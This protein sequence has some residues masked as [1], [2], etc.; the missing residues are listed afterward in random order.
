M[1]SVKPKLIIGMPIYNGEKFIKLRLE[2]LLSQKFIDFKLIISDNASTDK[3]E[4]ICR[5]FLMKDDRI[6]Y[7]R[8]KKNIGS[9]KN[10]IFVL[11]NADS[12]YFAWIAVDDITMPEFFDETINTLN[13]N[14][15]LVGCITKSFRYGPNNDQILKQIPLHAL[16]GSYNKKIRNYLKNPQSDMLYSVFRTKKLQKSIINDPISAWDSATILS[17]LRYGDIE[18]LDKSLIQFFNAG[19]SSKSVKTRLQMEPDLNKIRFPQSFFV[20]WC[21]KHFGLKFFIKN[22]DIFMKLFLDILKIM[23]KVILK[24]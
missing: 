12:D 23:V 11:E 7:F 22:L 10:F 9:R 2:S 20:F 3:T 18:V 19:I 17:V 15:K 5:E 13:S 24:K 6:Q 14:D 16:K 8:Q 21:Y 1:N 4:Q